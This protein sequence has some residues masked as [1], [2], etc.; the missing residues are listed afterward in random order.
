MVN[1]KAITDP[2][3]VANELRPVTMKLAREL[4]REAHPLGVTGNQVTLLIQ[5]WKNPTIGVRELAALEGV[6][7]AAISGHVRRLEGAGLIER[8]PDPHDRRRHALVV[9]TGGEGVIRSVKRRRTA[10][11]AERM[12]TLAPDELAAIET[13]IAPL[14]R[15]LEIAE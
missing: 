6:S 14:R 10:W 15:L 5:I 2:V 13:A 8:V 12:K 3:Q 9:T 1:V 7:P 11:L 4:R